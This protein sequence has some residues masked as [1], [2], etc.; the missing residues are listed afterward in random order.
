[1]GDSEEI[2]HYLVFIPVLKIFLTG[3]RRCHGTDFYVD[4]LAPSLSMVEISFDL[5]ER[6][7]RQNIY[8]PLMTQ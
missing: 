6:L 7:L 3:S 2:T 8:A 5:M 1:M 4:R